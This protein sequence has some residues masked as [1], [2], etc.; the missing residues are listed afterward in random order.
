M[1]SGQGQGTEL[2]RLSVLGEG[3]SGQDILCIL[4]KESE[5]SWEPCP[6][7]RPPSSG[8][9]PPPSVFL[10]QVPP[11]ML[12]GGRCVCAGFFLSLVGCYLLRQWVPLHLEPAQKI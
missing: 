3:C 11:R 8:P 1:P 10:I 12:C 2:R 4:G 6:P 5:D 7:A 9:R